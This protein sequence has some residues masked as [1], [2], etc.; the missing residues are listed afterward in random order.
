V[1]PLLTATTLGQGQLPPRGESHFRFTITI[2]KDTGKLNN[3][4]EII[5]KNHQMNVLPPCRGD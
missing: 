4:A 5:H 2:N 1:K 3:I